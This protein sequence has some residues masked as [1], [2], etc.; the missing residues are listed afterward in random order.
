MATILLVEDDPLVSDML[1][2]ILERA[3]HTVTCANNGEEAAAWLKQNTPDILITDII[4]PKKSGITL[5]SEVKTS[6][7]QLEIIAISGGGR[8]DPNGYLDLSES[9]GATVSFEKPINN[10]AL[11]MAIDLLIHGASG[12]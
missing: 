4:M 5:I 11:L 10:A 2:Q 12:E 3:S 8:L 9:L 6:H 7:P 1:K